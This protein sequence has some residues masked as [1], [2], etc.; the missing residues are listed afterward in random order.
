MKHFEGLTVL[1]VHPITTEF[2]L[3]KSLISYKLSAISHM[4]PMLSLGTFFG[5]PVTYPT[6]WYNWAVDMTES[7]TF[8]LNFQLFTLII[9]NYS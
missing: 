1:S 4:C 6:A 5:F 9:S 2:F 8:G 7:N 3:E